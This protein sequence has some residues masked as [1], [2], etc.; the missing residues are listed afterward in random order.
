MT[1]DRG[2]TCIYWKAVAEFELSPSEAMFMASIADLSKNNAG[3][4]YASKQH[5]AETL[6]V[7]PPTIYKLI[8]QLETKGLVIK[9]GK[10]WCGTIYL[11][12]TELWNESIEEAKKGIAKA[13]E[14]KESRNII[15]I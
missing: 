1:L 5:L 4:C 3:M 8:R 12:P 10:S 7:S 2:Y 6:R 15:V 11:R 13:K 9:E 14:A